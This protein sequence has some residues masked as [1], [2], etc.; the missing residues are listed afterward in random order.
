MGQSLSRFMVKPIE[1]PKPKPEEQKEGPELGP[2]LPHGSCLAV[3]FGT[4]FSKAA[5]V[6][7]E[8]PRKG[9]NIVLK[10]Q[11][12]KKCLSAIRKDGD[13]VIYGEQAVNEGKKNDSA[14]FA[15]KPL[16]LKPEIQEA[17][18]QLLK[19]FSTQPDIAWSRFVFNVPSKI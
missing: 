13:S 8:G 17:L 18:A 2:F 15:F 4:Y 3:D 14:L 6:Y 16:I 7:A 11:A 1:S 10:L 9:S 5:Y 19:K 12:S